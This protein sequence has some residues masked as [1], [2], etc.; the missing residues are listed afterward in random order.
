M[1]INAP[2]IVS[3]QSY[4]VSGSSNFA[5]GDGGNI[6]LTGDVIS[7]LGHD[8]PAILANSGLNA[9]N[10]FGGVSA[11]VSDNPANGGDVVITAGSSIDLDDTQVLALAE[12]STSTGTAGSITLTAPVVDIGATVVSALSFGAGA[13]GNVT[14]NAPTS[15]TLHDQALVSAQTAGAGAGGSVQVNAGALDISG[16]GFGAASENWL[17]AAI[18]PQ[19]GY[20]VAPRGSGIA[21]SAIGPATGAAGSVGIDV[22]T[23]AMNGTG[24]GQ[25]FV[26]IG[27][28]F[29]PFI[30]AGAFVVSAASADAASGGGIAINANTSHINNAL[31]SSTTSGAGDAGDIVLVGDDLFLN[32][33]DVRSE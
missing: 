22:D 7:I 25:G 11:T 26:L 4:L 19:L 6:S 15:A 28:E 29:V 8:L 14:I 32:G 12:G 18:E 20:T 16:I 23:L 24:F 3:D 13:S 5:S 27:S 31:I 1:S 33:A 17:L 21:A 9:D 10:G 30:S 2:T